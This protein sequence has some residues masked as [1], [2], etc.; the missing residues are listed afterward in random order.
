MSY[1]IT[2]QEHNTQLQSGNTLLLQA[3]N[4]ANAL[5]NVDT[6]TEDLTSELEEQATLI[7]E[8]LVELD[9][10][11][12]GE[13]VET[14]TVTLVNE[15]NV[16][17]PVDFD[18]YYTNINWEYTWTDDIVDGRITIEVPKS[19][20]IFLCAEYM[21]ADNLGEYVSAN[22]QESDGAMYLGFLCLYQGRDM[23]Q[24]DCTAFLITGDCTITATA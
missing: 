14:C 24:W 19:T 2:L 10:K 4:K 16:N 23:A 6:S 17:T 21:S 11:T 1:K 12:S 7:D 8:L 3:I 20:C 5:P 15:I 13:T 22:L 18:V 9:K